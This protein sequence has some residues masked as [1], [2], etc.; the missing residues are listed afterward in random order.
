MKILVNL[1]DH[2]NDTLE[3]IEEYAKQ[4]YNIQSLGYR[5][6]ANDYIKISE[7]I[8]KYLICYTIKWYY[9]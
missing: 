3:E 1:I 7:S 9:S 2:A 4:A 6:L 8:L 5:D